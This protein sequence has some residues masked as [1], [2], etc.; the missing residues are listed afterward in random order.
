MSPPQIGKVLLPDRQRVRR[1][2][3]YSHLLA[4]CRDAYAESCLD[5]RKRVMNT[6]RLALCADL[7]V[8]LWCGTG[9]PVNAD[10]IISVGSYIPPPPYAAL[11]T[12]VV[13]I[14]ITVAVDVTFWQ[15][16]LSY[17]ASDVQINT[18]CDPFSD[19]YCS[20]FTGP[21]TEGP[22][23]GSLSPFN[24]FNPGFILLDG[25]TLEQLGQLI[26]VNDS[27]GGSLPGPSGDGI[28]AYVEFITTAIG[29]GESPIT[30][31]GG[32]TTSSAPEPSTLALFAGALV[33][34]GARR[35]P[36]LERRSLAL[37]GGR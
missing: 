21:V 8:A 13:P 32:S 17:D 19:P 37:A 6:K 7:A 14:N 36:G 20:L 9:R 16:D 26:A 34:L 2:V 10:P 18:G 3:A 31:V 23:F 24:V 5:R 12:F 28:L 1:T 15:F 27:F 22:F 30:V 33:L 29:T 4:R 35:L 11:T 25:I